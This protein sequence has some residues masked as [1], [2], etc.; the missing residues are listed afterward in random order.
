ME[1][2]VRNG[3]G[4]EK[5]WRNEKGGKGEGGEEREGRREE[6]KEHE[7]KVREGKR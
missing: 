6:R 2:E 7:I 5:R 3:I 4:R 1:T